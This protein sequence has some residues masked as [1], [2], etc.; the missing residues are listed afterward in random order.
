MYRQPRI[1]DATLTPMIT[2]SMVILSLAA[3]RRERGPVLRPRS[4]DIVLLFLRY[5]R[6]RATAQCLV[7]V[8]AILYLELEGALDV[9][10]AQVHAV[11]GIIT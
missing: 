3:L 4:I 9:S 8:L 6:D 2:A 11:S 10:M 1:H 7:I 5:V